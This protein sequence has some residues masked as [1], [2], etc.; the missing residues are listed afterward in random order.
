VIERT[1]PVIF[2][3]GPRQL[4]STLVTG[5]IASAIDGLGPADRERL[6][7]AIAELARPLIR[8]GALHSTLA[9]HIAIATR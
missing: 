4:E 9:S 8:D 6:A 5:G 3:G 2:E 7:Q 1:L